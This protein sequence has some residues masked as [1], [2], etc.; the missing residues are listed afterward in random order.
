MLRRNTR[1]RRIVTPLQPECPSTRELCRGALCHDELHRAAKAYPRQRR[2]PS[3]SAGAHKRAQ[4]GV[5]SAH[6]ASR[7]ALCRTPLMLAWK[8]RLGTARAVLRGGRRRPRPGPASAQAARWRVQLHGAH[9]RGRRA[10]MWQALTQNRRPR[11]A[12]VLLQVGPAAAEA[13]RRRVR[14]LSARR[15][16]R[17]GE[18]GR[19]GA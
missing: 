5:L 17:H 19:G 7:R 2:A 18:R 11:Q 8:H 4:M 15:R 16:A 6:A 1:R 9:G 14:Q 10:A 3:R 12:R 13:Q